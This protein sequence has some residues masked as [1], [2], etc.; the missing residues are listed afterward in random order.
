MQLFANSFADITVNTILADALYGTEVFMDKASAIFQGVQ[1]ISQ[2][3]GNQLVF[4]E[5]S[6]ISLEKLFSLKPYYPAKIMLRGKLVKVSFSYISVK[7]KAHTGKKR[8]IVALKYDG[9]SE[10]R[11]LVATDLSWEAE[12]II[13]TYSLRWLVEVFFQDWKSYEGWGQLTKHTGYDGSVRG[14][15]LSLLLDHCLLFHPEQK[16]QIDGKLP[17]FTVGSLREKVIV[18]SLMQFITSLLNSKK[19]KEKLKNLVENTDIIFQPNLSSK[20]MNTIN[21]GFTKRKK[22][23]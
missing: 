6:W 2:L 23:A 13:K 8:K 10:Y 7:V 15:I 11:Y 21:I 22:V 20:H 16:A 19:P 14:L 12:T 1:V 18:E 9:E 17:A 4:H 3:R 5:N